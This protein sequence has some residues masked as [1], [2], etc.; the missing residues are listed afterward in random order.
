MNKLYETIKQ[1]I[2]T[3]DVRQ[4]TEVFL[5][6][7]TPENNILLEILNEL[8]ISVSAILDGDRRKENT[9]WC[10][11]KVVQ[12]EFIEN[13]NKD[14]FCVI[15]WS[16]HK[17]FMLERLHELGCKNCFEIN[18]DRDSAEYLDVR[19]EYLKEAY[20][21]WENISSIYPDDYYLV[22]PRASGDLYLSLAYVKKWK[23][24]KN[25]QKEICIIGQ[26]KNVS[27]VCELYSINHSICLA[28]SDRKKIVYLSSVDNELP[29]KLLSPWELNIRSSYFPAI[30]DKIFFK[31]K[32]RYEVFDL[33]QGTKAEF[34][35]HSSDKSQG[36]YIIV[37]PYAY[38][39]PV[40][41]LS[42]EFWEKLVIE[43]M[44][45]G[46][47]VYTLGYGDMELPIKNTERIQFTYLEAGK[48][49]SKG[50]GLISVRSGLCDILHNVSCDKVILFSNLKNAVSSDFY[51]MRNNYEEFEGVEI[52]CDNLSEEMIIDMILKESGM[53]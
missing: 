49:L 48:I 18:I 26:G 23:Q 51:G 33:C 13:I 28:E 7:C 21:V 22:A 16:M 41:Q 17:V 19:L 30:N 27:D 36:E 20:C 34:P 11:Q 42:V 53:I 44:K 37:A 24:Q 2:I 4:Y 1:Y 31:D 8:S 43:I 3:N 39:S 50:K 32:Y 45:K 52:L 6:G 47:K 25:I 38:S 29:I 46:I 35:K 9:Q 14:D 12:P 40:P 15:V 5:Y 10:G